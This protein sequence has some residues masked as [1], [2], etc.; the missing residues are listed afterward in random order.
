M[1]KARI[2]NC[3]VYHGSF[4]TLKENG[5]LNDEVIKSIICCPYAVCHLASVV[6]QIVNTYLKLLASIYQN[7]YVIVSQTLTAIINRMPSKNRFHLL[8]KVSTYLHGYATITYSL[9]I[10][11]VFIL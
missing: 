4:H 10:I 9:Q 3:S 11:F 2:G 7:S 6:Y 1:V 5:F 8:S